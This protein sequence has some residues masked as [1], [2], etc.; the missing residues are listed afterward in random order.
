MKAGTGSVFK[1]KRQTSGIL[2]G[3]YWGNQTGKAPSTA[4]QNGSAGTKTDYKS[5]EWRPPQ[6][7]HL[8][9]Q[10]FESLR[11]TRFRAQIRSVRRPA[12]PRVRLWGNFLE[13]G[14]RPTPI[15]RDAP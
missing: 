6:I 8:R 4:D 13:Q 12:P 14:S 7:S 11:S 5:P 10:G 3:N 9:G 2:W 15:Q 1:N